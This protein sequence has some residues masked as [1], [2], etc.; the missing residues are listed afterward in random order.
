[1][2]EITIDE[3][4]ELEFK[5]LL[6]IHAFCESH[7]IKYMLAYG[8]LLGCVR[9]KGFIPWDD[10]IDICMPRPDYDRFMR[11]YRHPYFKAFC[12]EYDPE[13]HSYISKVCDTR[14]Y[15][16]EGHGDVCGVYVDIFPIDGLPGSKTLINIHLRKARIL[17]SLWSNQHYTKKMKLYEASSF[18]KKAKI[19]TGRILGLIFSEDF[20]LRQIVKLRIRYPYDTSGFISGVC[21]TPSVAIPREFA[22]KVID[23]DFEGHRF[24]ISALYDSWL[25]VIY[26]DYMELPPVE[27]RINT[28]GF[29]AEWKEDQ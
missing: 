11:E 4:K 14:T 7:G 20:F 24:P 15:I 21:D 27:Q 18:L 2:K 19:L 23:G 17:L 29:N 10:D 6:D 26:G 28:H 1:M 9:H 13:W 3:L 16:D 25:K 12:P 22:E 5:I 8:T